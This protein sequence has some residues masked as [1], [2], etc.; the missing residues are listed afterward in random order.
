MNYGDNEFQFTIFVG[1]F[2]FVH[3]C[4]MF[5]CMYVCMYDNVQHDSLMSTCIGIIYVELVCPHYIF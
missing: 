2:S 3:A 5:L 1:G 4:L